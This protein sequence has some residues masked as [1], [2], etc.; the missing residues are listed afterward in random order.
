MPN[1]ETNSGCFLVLLFIVHI[2]SILGSGYYAWNWIEPDSFWGG[3]KF[4]IAWG[5]IG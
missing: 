1:S 4:L 3:I 5:I 2:V